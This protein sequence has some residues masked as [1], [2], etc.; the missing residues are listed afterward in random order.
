L[1]TCSVFLLTLLPFCAAYGQN[2]TNGQAARAVIGQNVFTA[3]ISGANQNLLGGASGLAFDSARQTLYVADANR[4]GATPLNHRVL[5]FPT[6]AIPGPRQDP[7]TSSSGDASCPVCGYNASLV[8]GQTNFTNVNPGRSSQ[9]TDSAGSLNSPIAVATDGT[10]L[11]VA[12]TDNNRVLI[13]KSIPAASNAAPDLV[14]GQPDFTTLQRPQ[15]VDAKSLRGPQG[16]WINNGKLFVADTQNHRI[17]VWN[18]IPTQN[19]QN[20][21]LVLGQS[22]FSHADAP[23][24]SSSNPP[25]A[26]NRLLNPVAV[27]TDPSGTHLFVADL[28]FSRVLIWNSVPTTTDQNA[29]VVIGQPDMVSSGA[30]NSS[31]VCTSDGNDSNGNPIYPS[32]C[33]AT[34]N[35]PRYALSDGT[36]LFVADGGNDRVLI[37]NSIPTRNAAKANNVLGQPD[38]RTNVSTSAS[39]SIA[40]TAIDNTAAVDLTPTPMSLAWDGTNLYVSDPYNRRVEIFSPADVALPQFSAVNWASEIIRQEGIVTLAVT[41][42]GAITANDTVTITIAGKDYT[43]TVKSGDSL[44]AIAQ[45]LVSAINANSGDPNATA[46]FAGSGSGA[47][48]LSSRGANLAFDSISLAASTSNSANL[49]VTAS[50]GYLSAGTAAT[51]AAGMLVEINGTNLSDNT[52]P[53]LADQ[54]N[55]ATLPTT[56]GGAQVFMDGLPAPLMSVSSTQI[57][58]VI[59]FSYTDRN[60]T[61]LFVRTTHGNGQPTATTASPIY[62]APANPGIFNAPAFS[63][64]PRPWPITMAR[65][66]KNNP[67]AVVSIDGTAKANDTV[68]ITIAGTD[69][70]YTVVANDTLA[71]I[72]TGLVNKINASDPNVTASAGAAFTRVVLTAKQPAPAGTGISVKVSA[73]SNAQV[74]PTA[75]TDSTCCSVLPDKPIEP[76]NPAVPGELIQVSAAGLGSVADLAGNVQSITAGQPYTGAQTNT[77]TNS[78]SATMGGST[79]QVI[80]AGLEQG[81]YGIY[82]VQMIVPSSL[83]AN[84]A[85]QLYIAQN[86]FISNTVTVPVGPPGTPSGPVSATPIRIGVDSPSSQGTYSGI[87]GFGGWAIDDNTSISSVAAS[88]DGVA[89]GSASYGGNR[90]DVCAAF[91]GRQGCP[92]VGW[93]MLLDTTRFADGSHAL[94]MTATAADGVRFT[95]AAPFKVSNGSSGSTKVF[96]DQPGTQNGTYRGVVTFSGWAVNTGSSISSRTVLIDGS[97][98]GQVQPMARPDVCAAYASADC[99]NVGWSY[100]LDTNSLSNG[101]HTFSLRATSATGQTATTSSQFTVANW[102]TSNPTRISIDTPNAQ[103]ASFRGVAAFGGWAINDVSAISNVTVAVD[104]VTFG[105]AAYGSNRSDVCN[106]FAGRPGCP[107]VGWNVGVDT[108]TIADGPHSL[109]ITAVPATGQPYTATTTFTVANG[110]SSRLDAMIDTPSPQAAL[111]GSVNFRGWAVGGFAAVSNVQLLVDGVSIGQALYGVPRADVCA[112]YPTSTSCQSSNNVGWSLT[113]DTNQLPNGSHM[114]EARIVS[115]SNQ[116]RTISAPFT[117]S[118]SAP[119]GPVRVFI[120]NPNGQ[121]LSYQGL[122]TF[123]GWAIDDNALITSVSVTVDGIPYGSGNYGSVSRGDVCS[124]YPGR[125]NCANGQSGVGWTFQL[126][127]TRLPDGS[128]SLGIT[129]VAS[130]G[131]FLTAN[132]GFTVANYSGGA[133]P[134]TIDIDSPTATNSSFKGVISANGWAIDN[135]G[136]ISSIQVA[137]DGTPIGTAGYGVNRPDVCSIFSGRAN[138]PNVGW[139]ISLDTALIPNGNHTFVVTAFTTNG[140]SSTN[141]SSFSTLN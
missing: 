66:Q 36:R 59:P 115:A 25:A 134:I 117:V 106:A 10:I 64:Q 107:N 82:N 133:S 83:S 15:V 49:T 87:V 1:R 96:I 37:F 8:L 27:T 68:T 3:A 70:T 88:V 91:P 77:A 21:D 9:A 118:N 97:P 137:V 120:D 22:D 14:L 132:V 127:T 105:N 19:N 139:G 90:D 80:S 71:S 62:I 101:T 104:G 73:S 30:N 48:Y 102:S 128:H 131:R 4:V 76:G 67:A 123:N 53:V 109:A 58:S 114:L 57:V 32:Q 61:S 130:D 39:I 84:S 43:Y 47:V 99:P 126:D 18:R 78:V 100:L 51:G 45:G 136:T 138:C 122:A 55:G 54:K 17:L 35:Y 110:G 20:A 40:S 72:V 52:T 79:A 42:G 12:D 103:S 119:N 111:T 135:A 33:E 75:Y 38:F 6:T 89:Y 31:A 46:L 65:H 116:T 86:A 24:P 125:P 11:A 50:G 13:W 108:T 7:T 81:S 16:V 2:F 85:T 34:L 26:A 98:L 56:L 63:G 74:T 124:A 112:T 129:A 92:N 121:S 140:Q 141:T 23:P 60:S 44:D 95:V 69:Y 94:Q 5:A 28:G 29:D 41:A 113:Y 93:S